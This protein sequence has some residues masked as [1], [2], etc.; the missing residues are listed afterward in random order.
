MR[1]L[2]GSVV[3][4]LVGWLGWVERSKGVCGCEL[5]LLL[6]VFASGGDQG[7]DG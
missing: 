7:V 6:L 5:G 3:C 1:I 4:L 2:P